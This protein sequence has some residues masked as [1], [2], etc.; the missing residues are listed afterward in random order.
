VNKERTGVSRDG[1]VLGVERKEQKTEENDI[2]WV[3][4]PQINII[5]LWIFMS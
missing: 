2:D 4:T 5:H 1:I 3:R